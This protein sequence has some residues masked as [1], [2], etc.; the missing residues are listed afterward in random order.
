[1]PISSSQNDNKVQRANF[2]QHNASCFSSYMF[3]APLFNNTDKNLILTGTSLWHPILLS[4]MQN[5]PFQY[6]SLKIGSPF[7]LYIPVAC[8]LKVLCRKICPLAQ[9]SERLGFSS[10]REVMEKW[11]IQQ[12]INLTNSI[13]LHI[14]QSSPL[15]PVKKLNEIG[16]ITD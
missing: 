16:D 8:H 3:I 2:F 14:I 11:S 1:M 12:H 7:F 9:P 13:V 6:L 15:G 10:L 5:C 4:Q